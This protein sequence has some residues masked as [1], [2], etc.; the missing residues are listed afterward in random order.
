FVLFV[1]GLFAKE[2]FSHILDGALRTGFADIICLSDF[3]SPYLPG[4]SNI[5]SILMI[6][7]LKNNKS[8]FLFL[9]YV[10]GIHPGI[11]IP[12]LLPVVRKKKPLS[13]H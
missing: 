3:F 4:L 8:R 11:E 7:Y 10:S 9:T 1:F 5:H 2:V 13:S 12:G 6:Q